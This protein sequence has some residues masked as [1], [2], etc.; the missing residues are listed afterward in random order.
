MLTFGL[1]ALPHFLQTGGL[2]AA[3]LEEYTGN[4]DMSG[5]ACSGETRGGSEGV[6]LHVHNCEEGSLFMCSLQQQGCYLYA[7]EGVCTRS[8][9]G[10]KQFTTEACPRQSVLP[11]SAERP[12]LH[13]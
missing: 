2:G 6:P 1:P 9:E 4:P 7:M 8:E 10:K 3:E 5:S 12:C 11:A 13:P